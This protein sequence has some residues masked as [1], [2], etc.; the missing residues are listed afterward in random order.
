MAGKGKCNIFVNFSL[1][2]KCS[3][4]GCLI[5]WSSNRWVVFHPSKQSMLVNPQTMLKQPVILAEFPNPS[6]HQRESTKTFS[7]LA[8]GEPV[9]TGFGRVQDLLMHL[10]KGYPQT[11]FLSLN[12]T[13]WNNPSVPFLE[14][15]L[16]KKTIH[17]IGA[18]RPKEMCAY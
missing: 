10:I 18:T 13:T 9:S 15:R 11:T 6:R 14:Q 8:F 1:V 12:W 2:S 3:Y 17:N 5:N 7:D 16:R 4:K